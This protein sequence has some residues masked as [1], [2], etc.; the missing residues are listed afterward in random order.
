MHC[1]TFESLLDKLDILCT[2]WVQLILTMA[3]TA[4]QQQGTVHII[5]CQDS[6]R[7]SRLCEILRHRAAQVCCC[8]L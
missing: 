5:D 7:I 3:A 6:I 4:L 8:A 1:D 2:V